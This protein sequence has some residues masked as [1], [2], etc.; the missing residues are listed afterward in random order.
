MNFY[1]ITY[2]KNSILK[3]YNP[4]YGAIKGISSAWWHHLNNTWI[5]KTHLNSNDISNQLNRHIETDDKLLIIQVFPNSDFSGWLTQDAW[6][7]LNNQFGR[8]S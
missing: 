4:L 6:D 8:V 3:N 2:S 5:I 1:V 7:W